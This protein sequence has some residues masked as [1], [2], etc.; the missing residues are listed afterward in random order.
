[1]RNTMAD[2]AASGMYARAP[3]KKTRINTMIA[4][5]TKSDSWLRPPALSTICVFV[6]LPLTTKVPDSPA[7]IGQCQTDQVGILAESIVVERGKG[8]RGRCALGQDDHEHR[9]GRRKQRGHDWP[10]PVDLGQT[11]VGDHSERLR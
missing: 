5:V 7:N 3:V 2:N 6:G 1:M 4:T 11:E 9:K 8:A 10:A